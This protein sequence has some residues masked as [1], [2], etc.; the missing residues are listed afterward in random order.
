MNP[1]WF[2]MCMVVGPR[3][4]KASCHPFLHIESTPETEKND[5]RKDYRF[6][7]APGQGFEPR[8]PGSE[9]GVLPLDDPGM[10]RLQA[11]VIIISLPSQ[12]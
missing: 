2:V 7:L 8:L 4:A 12:Q 11:D 6:S 3:Q 9:P 1:Q 10:C 5:H